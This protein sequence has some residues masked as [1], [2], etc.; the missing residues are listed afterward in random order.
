MYIHIWDIQ[1]DIYGELPV[2]A[3]G[4]SSL[5]IF[6]VKLRQSPLEPDSHLVHART[7]RTHSIPRKLFFISHARFSPVYAPRYPA[8]CE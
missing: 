7:V 4:F 6:E 8:G 2:A 1:V 5:E 3:R